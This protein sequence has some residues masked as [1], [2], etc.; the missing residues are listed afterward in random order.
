MMVITGLH[1][2]IR[3]LEIELPDAVTFEPYPTL[4]ALEPLPS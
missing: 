1:P 4:D 3:R 2:R